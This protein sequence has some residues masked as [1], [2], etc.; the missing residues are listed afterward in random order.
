[1][2]SKSPCSACCELRTARTLREALAGVGAAVRCWLV[3]LLL[4]AGGAAVAA[5]V[6]A[7]RDTE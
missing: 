2:D 3:V 4:A 5:G 1:M 7:L 6:Q